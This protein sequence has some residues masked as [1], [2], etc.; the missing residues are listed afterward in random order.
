MI[1][2]S[3]AL[4]STRSLRA[5]QFTGLDVKKLETIYQAK[6]VLLCYNEVGVKEEMARKCT[7]EDRDRK[8]RL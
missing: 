5:S 4:P 6:T 1:S 7:R 8:V 3:S 2:Q